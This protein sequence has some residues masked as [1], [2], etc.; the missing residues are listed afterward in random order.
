[1]NQAQIVSTEQDSGV[2]GLLIVLA[3]NK[4]LI[5][6]LPVVIGMLSIALSFLMPD[7][8]QSR[9]RML[10]PQQAQSSASALLSQLGGFAGMTGIA[11]LKNPN[12]LYVAMLKSRTL[13]ERLVNRFDLKKTY[14][15]DSLER[16]LKRLE[17]NTTITSGKDGLIIIEVEDRDRDRAARMANGYVEELL[18]LSKG[19]AL[20]E[21]SQRRVFFERQLETAKNNLAAAEGSLKGAIEARGVI[22]VDVE[23]RSV[24][25]TVGRLRAQVSA[26]E[27]ELNSMQAFVT[28]NNPNYKRVEQ[29]LSSLR[30]QLATLEN[31]R[32]IAVNKETTKPG[33]LENIKLLRD[34]KYYE[35]LYELL[36]KQYEIS[37]LDE[38]KDPA[39]FQVLDYAVPAERKFK[40]KRLLLGILASSISLFIAIFIAFVGEAKRQLLQSPEGTAKWLT[41]KSYLK[42]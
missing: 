30:S 23:S 25:E 14:E 26:K 36:A 31:G 15:T 37:R 24:L 9:T 5:V 4:K 7:I 17:D 2:I 12:D 34:V 8:Y 38:A 40:P 6:G 42:M 21:S 28:S 16:T 22:S 1:M 33:G 39:I 32:G 41:F 19:L 27:V 20:T 18:K 11:G 29:E 13:A 3:K 35:M 10:P